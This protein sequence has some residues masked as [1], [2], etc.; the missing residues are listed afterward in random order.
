MRSEIRK[1]SSFNLSYLFVLC[2][3]GTP[4]H[5]SPSSYLSTKASPKN[6]AYYAVNPFQAE[7]YC[8][9]ILFI[10]VFVGNYKRI[11]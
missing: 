5:P 9:K 10:F 11:A 3:G 1:I 4:L 7:I 8:G 2:E 6:I